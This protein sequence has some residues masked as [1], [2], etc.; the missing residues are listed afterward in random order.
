MN[1]KIELSIADLE[2]VA[3]GNFVGQAINDIAAQVAKDAQIRAFLSG[4]AAGSSGAGSGS[5]SGS[6]SGT[7]RK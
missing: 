6:G 3:G 7:T 2:T 1:T 5:G 4:F